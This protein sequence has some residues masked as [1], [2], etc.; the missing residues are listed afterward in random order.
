MCCSSSV[1]YESRF[2]VSRAA[3]V[4]YSLQGCDGEGAGILDTAYMALRGTMVV[5]Y[6][7]RHD[8]QVNRFV[9]WEKRVSKTCKM[10][11]G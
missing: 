4:E 3:V 11:G 5:V 10:G 2:L 1:L 7:C 8:G 9:L 6:W